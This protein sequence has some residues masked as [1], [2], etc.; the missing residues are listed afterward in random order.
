[1]TY[2]PP[3]GPEPAER[4]ER[5]EPGYPRP[6]Y[7]AVPPQ[8]QVPQWPYLGVPPYVNAP[9]Y[10]P[11]LPPGPSVDAVGPDHVPWRFWDVVLAA[12]PFLLLLSLT[13]IAH[14]ASSTATSTTTD[15][16]T[17]MNVLIANT[18]VGFIV[19][20]VILLL[21]WLVT[22]RK[23]HVGWSTLGVRRPPGLW[24]ALAI[25]VLLGMYIAAALVS[26]II[27]TLFYGGKAENPQVKDITGGGS[28]SWL[29]L[30]LALA[31][32]SI[33]APIVEEL[34]FRGLLYGWLRTRLGVVPGVLLSA[35][36]FS[37]AH[38]IP[39]ILASILVVGATLAIV[40]EKT[41]STLATMTLHS[42]FNTVGV[43]LVFIDLAR[44]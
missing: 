34:F 3:T 40:Y 44:K 41:K 1:M 19:Y 2:P 6:D 32:A 14:F 15:T 8:P 35:M 17:S 29:K 24:W 22:V 43:V 5:T 13:L 27:V 16:P 28:F 30:I 37:G 39:L 21:I 38:A 25:P 9:G 36:L 20:G 7:W 4:T 26:A 42:L 11:P 12:L 31:T 33:A 23:Y 18:V 10:P